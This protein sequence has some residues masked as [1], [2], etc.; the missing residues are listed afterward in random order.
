[1]SARSLRLRLLLL[2][3]LSIGV[4]LSVAGISLVYIFE[5]HLEQRVAQELERRLIELASAFAV[6]ANGVPQLARE[7][8]EQ[9]IKLSCLRRLLAPLPRCEQCFLVYPR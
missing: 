7:L 2:A 5:R 6:D 9:S 1:M 3:A 4:T 8:C